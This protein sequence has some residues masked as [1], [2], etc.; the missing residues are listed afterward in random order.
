MLVLLG[1]AAG[2]AQPATAVDLAKGAGRAASI[3]IFGDSGYIPSYERLDEDDPPLRS[4][5]DYLAAEARDWLERNPS[6]D[7][8]TPTPWTFESA[9]GSYMPASGLYP[10]ARRRRRR[11]SR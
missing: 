6:L 8:F 7:G 4:L 5:G 1:V 11:P 3:V 9:L 2:A 10:V